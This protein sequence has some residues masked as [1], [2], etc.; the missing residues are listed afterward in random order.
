MA[1][2]SAH[3]GYEYQ[4]LITSFFILKNILSGRNS[5]FTIDRKN[6][7][8][9]DTLDK[10]DD[11]VI[12]TDNY[13]E[14]KQFKY[15]NEQNAKKFTKDDLSSDSQSKLALDTLFSSWKELK[16][17]DKVSDFRLCLAWD[18][19]V[20][21]V[22]DVLINT[23]TI[24]TS[25]NDNRTKIFQVDCEKLW[26]HDGQPL[27]GWRRFRAKSVSIERDEFLT[28]CKD[29]II[30]INFPKASLDLST[31]GP[32][33]K[34]VLEAVANLGIGI[35]PNEDKNEKGVALNL[36]NMVKKAR[37]QS[38]T[39]STK[40]IIT[41]L[42]LST[43]YGSIYQEFEIDERL[44]VDQNR[45]I[46]EFIEDING[47]NKIIVTGAP[48]SGKSWFI[49]N[50]INCL[51]ERG[52]KV[53]K[54]YCFVSTEDDLQAER[55]KTNTFYGN[56]IADI[57]QCFPDVRS[58]KLTP[59][60]A[61]L[62][63]LNNI[64]ANINEE[65][66]IFID[67]LDHINR[68][69]SKYT[70][71][72]AGEEIQIIDK[73]S[74]IK[75]PK[76]VKVILGTQ[77]IKD[78]DELL[79][80]GYR[81]VII[82]DW[83]INKVNGLLNKYDVKNNIFDSGHS[84]SNIL[85]EKSKGNPLYLSYLLKTVKSGRLDDE[86]LIDEIPQYDYNLSAY[87]E[88]LLSK[89]N[90]EKIAIIFS[91]IE[92][93]V[94]D[95]EMREI[96]GLGQLAT[97]NINVLLPILRQN[98]STGGFSIYHESFR[99]FI[100]EKLIESGVKVEK[101]VYR[102]IIEWLEDKGYYCSPKAYKHLIS[103][104]FESKRYE[105]IKE[106]I[107]T[108]FLANSLIYGYDKESIKNNYK[109]FVKTAEVTMD[110]GLFAL[111]SEISK[112]IYTYDYSDF[113]S[114]DFELYFQ[115]IFYVKGIDIARNALIYEGDINLNE[116]YG[117]KGCYAIDADNL[118]L[119]WSEYINEL[120]DKLS[121]DIYKYFLRG[122]FRV[123]GKEFLIAHLNDINEVKYKHFIDIFVQEFTD[124]LGI[125][126]ILDLYSGLSDNLDIW[127]I[128]INQYI[129]KHIL[130]IK[131]CI[132]VL[133]DND[134][135]DNISEDILLVEHVYEDTMLTI[136]MFIDQI[137]FFAKNGSE[138]IREF[139]N[140]AQN[141]NWFYNWIIFVCEY[142]IIKNNWLN[143][144]M[145]QLE[146]EE[147]IVDCYKLL[148]IDME[149]FKG[150]P[151]TCDLYYAQ[152]LIYDIIREPLLLIKSQGSWIKVFSYLKDVATNTTTS[153]QGSKGG[154]L[155]T[156]K[157]FDLLLEFT[158]TDNAE[159][160]IALAEQITNEEQVYGLYIYHARYELNKSILYAKG[161]LN[162][163]ANESLLKAVQ[164]ITAY[165]DS[166]DI[167]LL[168]LLD[169]IDSLYIVNKETADC[170]MRDLKL[171]CDAASNHTDGSET[172]W[173]PIQWFKH[174]V[175][176][177][178]DDA[179]IYLVNSFKKVSIDWRLEDSLIDA[180]SCMN[181]IIDPE[182][183]TFIYKTFPT[184]TSQEFIEGYLQNVDKLYSK[185]KLSLANK[186]FS[187]IVNRF[188]NNKKI[189][190]DD[191][192]KQTITTNEDIFKYRKTNFTE[193]KESTDYRYPDKRKW[194]EKI[195]YGTN[196]GNTQVYEAILLFKEGICQNNQLR[197]KYFIE[198]FS[199]LT[200]ELKVF[201]MQLSN[202]Y[203]I[204]SEQHFQNMEEVVDDIN[205]HKEIK[206]YSY[207]C[208]FTFWRDGWGN[209]FTHTDILKKAMSLEKDKALVYLSELL[210]RVIY[211]PGYNSKITA[212]LINAFTVC[213]IDNTIV[214]NMWN[215]AFDMIEFRLPGKS[216]LD[217]NEYIQNT[218]SLENDEI[219]ICLLLVRLKHPE[220]RRQK[221]TLTG[222]SY[223][224]YNYPNKLIKPIKWF[225]KNNKEFLDVSIIS[226][227]Q[228]LLEYSATDNNY[229]ENFR[230]E[231]KELLPSH[232]FMKDSIITKL[233][234]LEQIKYENKPDER[235][236]ITNIDS[237]KVE[238]ISEKNSRNKFLSICIFDFATLV[239]K[240]FN[241]I[242]KKEYS[243]QV[244][245]M[246][247]NR[248]Y[249]TV[250]ENICFE[251]EWLKI[252][253]KDLIKLISDSENV[254]DIDMI[255]D[256]MSF[257]IKTI[258][259]YQNS[260]SHRP[261]IP[262]PPEINTN[263]D[264][265]EAKDGWVILANYEKQSQF[266]RSYT[267][268]TETLD[269]S[270]G[271]IVFGKGS[272]FPFSEYQLDTKR[273]W[274]V[275]MTGIFDLKHFR[276]AMVLSGIEH[277]DIERMYLLWTYPEILEALELK[278]SSFN[279]GIQAVNKQG[280]VILKLVCW[281]CDF[282]GYEKIT[283]EIAKLEGAQLLMRE[284]YFQ[285]LCSIIKA[286]PKYSKVVIR[287]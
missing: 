25:F 258:I 263:D 94:T 285:K 88:Y 146:L 276:N 184:E 269:Q 228:I 159:Y 149:P 200:N 220:V 213:G 201:I 162:D 280:D 102:D 272:K 222:I 248:M 48:G 185:G 165:G 34:L 104:L 271:G 151:R 107:N 230:H 152:S 16:D 6:I 113:Y 239:S 126:E 160:F 57:I 132:A 81:E 154:P 14:R 277:Q 233:L 29:L 86:I 170:R 206:I 191:S 103:L 183:V 32:L 225:V 264:S 128:S 168:E 11:L 187:D 91:G 76:N 28:F 173:F 52:I 120:D 89:L 221:W 116:E 142:S 117:L 31:P 123:N 223:L 243:E 251:N 69:Y 60:G 256:R 136:N 134:K 195:R 3:E 22:I 68:V 219:A 182:I 231:L 64:L 171:L 207:I 166:K 59:Y 234:A 135:F 119:P 180:L 2:N 275:P 131:Y 99:R 205:T 226:V 279:E 66:F 101:V 19:P 74:K 252:V 278:I 105:D 138:V 121:L 186:A 198:Q 35:Y 208:L 214:S 87:Y 46:T 98:Y 53:A 118:V 85:L 42:E 80:S 257:D 199:M 44:N 247:F 189:D 241:A 287:Q 190:Y 266:K 161:N 144:T 90:S 23:N 209:S 261:R 7:E 167:T 71:I 284:D 110:W 70:G 45:E 21:E 58:Y 163:E 262:L 286:K 17:H 114:S 229:S 96:S 143:G 172:K 177:Y 259:A 227:L 8:G 242:N 65:F 245:R 109:V 216:Q 250:V 197:L 148:V 49:Q 37:T 47:N 174:Y 38:A 255:F 92:F 196:L 67:G 158:N 122:N 224:L 145:S 84:L 265:I 39:I 202:S 12:V 232:N 156:D 273:I 210:K 137:K 178:I 93:S 55:I 140:K 204:A 215:N 13:I 179:I 192:I 130:P 270:I 79:R 78:I 237:A 62:D 18:E 169:S 193:K 153:L 73:V 217:W 253:N 157:F 125:E 41:K 75:V 112:N 139:I 194:W 218:M 244:G 43:N 24:Q 33:E 212:N 82:P 51:Y 124:L 111:L 4:D 27:A 235:T 133:S 249:E 50:F 54:H 164:Y 188:Y 63:E 108:K 20:D 175:K 5:T 72:L 30:E 56:L 281:E 283:D 254:M 61:N 36:L 106:Y 238:F 129:D 246:F 268:D 274:N 40:D 115:A 181:N 150:K 15:S 100:L 155:T 1:L 83:D 203:V 141:R 236:N 95:E 97:D 282:L 26:P 176:N 127:G 240:Y 260:L 77:P 211:E 10:F 9:S 267:D 147:Q